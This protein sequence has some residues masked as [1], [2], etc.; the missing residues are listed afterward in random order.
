[1]RMSTNEREMLLE[2]VDVVARALALARLG[3]PAERAAGDETQ[4]ALAR[5]QHANVEA[6]NP[7]QPQL[8]Q[9]GPQMNHVPVN[10]AEGGGRGGGREAGA[11]VEG[12][13][14]QTAVPGHGGLGSASWW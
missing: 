9:P 3:L 8:P 7:V 4:E 11:R 10:T 6:N 13:E 12:L 1:M 14:G 5:Q 2:N